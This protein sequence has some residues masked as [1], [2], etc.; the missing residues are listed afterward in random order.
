R[1]LQHRQYKDMDRLS[2]YSFVVQKNGRIL[3]EQ[4][5]GS[6]PALAAAKIQKGQSEEIDSG[7][8]VDA[9][10]RSS[11]G[12]VLAAVGHSNTGWLRHIYLFSL[13]FTLISLLL[14]GLASA[15]SLLNFL[16]EEYD[17]RLTAK[18]SLARRI[19]LWNV[20]LLAAAFLVIGFLTYRHFVESA[21]ETARADFA[22]RAE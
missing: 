13:L 1:I 20:S 3:V 7:D 2:D 6:L 18:G 11:D 15:N 10:A 12:T 9:V 19:H 17:F 16:P 4:G 22:Y 21:R 14:L 8:R 5:R